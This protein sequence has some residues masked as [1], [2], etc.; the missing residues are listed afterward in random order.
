MSGSPLDT[1]SLCRHNERM[2]KQTY[3][4]E[5]EHLVLLAVLG[6]GSAADGRGI[7]KAL[8]SRAGRDVSRSTAYTTL[9]RLVSKGYLEASMAAPTGE[10]GGRARRLFRPTPLGTEALRT[11]GQALMRMWAG[12]EELLEDA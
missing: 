4:G 9:E 10:G 6:L 5:F 1:C 2:N 3:L 7:R 11:S 12:H 8:A